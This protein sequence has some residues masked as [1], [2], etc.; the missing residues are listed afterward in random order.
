MFF[1]DLPCSSG[2]VRIELYLLAMYSREKDF[3]GAVCFMSHMIAPR[4]H[5]RTLLLR[6]TVSSRKKELP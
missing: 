1:F 3:E 6:R 5:E 4:A 2:S